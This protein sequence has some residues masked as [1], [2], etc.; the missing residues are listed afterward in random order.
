VDSAREQDCKAYRTPW[1]IPE[2][3]EAEVP[4]LKRSA[5]T[6]KLLAF[7]WYAVLGSV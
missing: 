3:G 5:G 7:A 1:N 2:R 4:P 6:A